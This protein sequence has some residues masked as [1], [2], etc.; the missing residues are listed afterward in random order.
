MA[1]IESTLAMTAATNL[2]L[3]IG[4]LVETLEVGRGGGACVGADL[5]AEGGVEPDLVDGRALVSFWES[6]RGRESG[7]GEALRTKG[8]GALGF[9]LA[10]LRA[11]TGAV[12]W[13]RIGK[14]FAVVSA[15]RMSWLC[16]LLGSC[17]S[18]GIQVDFSDRKLSEYCTS[19]EGASGNLTPHHGRGRKRCVQS[20]WRR[21][22]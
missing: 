13:G 22:R 5:N 6:L 14:K 4:V 10:R 18:T 19:P 16:I 17:L 8:E 15:A 21:N 9:E 2:S 7:V 1:T 12:D 3:S 20:R 11:D